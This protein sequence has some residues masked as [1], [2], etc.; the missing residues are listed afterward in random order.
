MPRINLNDRPTPNGSFEER[1]SPKIAEDRLNA[2]L[3]PRLTKIRDTGAGAFDP[4]NQS[5]RRDRIGLPG[6]FR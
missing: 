6:R 5:G 4:T 2:K 1:L 3:G